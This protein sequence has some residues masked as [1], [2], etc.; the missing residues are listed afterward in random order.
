M[1][2]KIKRVLENPYRIFSAL[3]TRGLFNR[4]GDEGYLKLLYRSQL[5]KKLDLENP[6]TYNEKLQWLKL[7]DRRPIYTTMVDKAAVK[8]YVASRIG[9]E[10]IIPTYGVWEHFDD[11]DFDALPEKFVLKTNHGCGGI[12]ICR[13]KAA[14]DKAAARNTL[15]NALKQE[16]YL[17]CR[18]WPY[19]N[20]PRRILAEAL[21]EDLRDGDL[22]DY[23]F[24]C[25]DGE[26][27]ALFVASQRQNAAEETKFD[28]FD[29]NYRHLP[30]T[31]GHPNAAVPPEKPEAFETMKQLA[32]KLSAGYPHIR[33]DFYEV[34]GQ[35]YFGEL[36]LYHWSGIVPFEPEA[37][38]RTFGDWLVLPEKTL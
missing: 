23:K 8:D 36:T 37:W 33:V 31:N 17:T 34:N 11:I 15:E 26:V 6:K 18:E 28:F 13:D 10:Y 3:A 38:D 24:F 30:F 5:G 20:V 14:L 35:V 4:M 1:A 22:R 12:V 16:Y 25:F 29:E 27:K 19:K 21:L 32:R 9:E 7:Y 2:N